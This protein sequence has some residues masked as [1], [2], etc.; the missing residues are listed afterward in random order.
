MKTCLNSLLI[1]FVSVLLLSCHKHAGETGMVEV[2][3]ISKFCAE[4]CVP[5]A[6]YQTKDQIGDM[7]YKV[8]WRTGDEIALVNI[9]QNRIDRYVFDGT[10]GASVAEEGTGIFKGYGD[11]SYSYLST[12]EVYAVYPYAAACLEDSKLKVVLRDGLAYTKQADNAAFSGNDI[13]VSQ[14]LDLSGSMS[15]QVVA[16]QRIITLLTV[17]CMIGES[18][19]ANQTISS[20]EIQISGCAG[21]VD[22]HFDGSGNPYLNENDG[23]TDSMTISLLSNPKLGDVSTPVVS[24]IPLIPS[25]IRPAAGGITLVFSNGTTCTVG[26]HRQVNVTLN[27][28]RYRALS[29]YESNYS[30][31]SSKA[32]A[33]VRDLAWWV[34]LTDVDLGGGSRSGEYSDGTIPV[35]HAGGYSNGENLPDV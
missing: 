5:E 11:A 13:Q 24:F 3:Q 20:L 17:N 14:R 30:L 8:I 28:N 9:T 34:E 10:D 12:D 25:S 4:Y 32:E 27:K 15:S 1:F 22:V 23:D 35:S 16:L 21:K 31:V 2:F 26:A 19:L 7:Y 6:E 29:F 33:I 18:T